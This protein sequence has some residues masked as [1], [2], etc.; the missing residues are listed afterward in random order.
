MITEIVIFYDYNSVKL[1][2]AKRDFGVIATFFPE[3]S[4]DR[5]GDL[6]FATGCPASR[7]VTDGLDNICEGDIFLPRHY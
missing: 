4:T 2:L 6:S 3:S 1:R 7:G 5:P